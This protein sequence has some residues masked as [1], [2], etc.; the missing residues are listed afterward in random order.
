MAASPQ[1][2]RET[3]WRRAAMLAYDR[4]GPDDV[5]FF[6]LDGTRYV[7]VPPSGHYKYPEV[8]RHIQRIEKNLPLTRKEAINP[9]SWAHWYCI[10]PITPR[11]QRSVVRNWDENAKRPREE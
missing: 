7:L 3:E 6:A 8:V 1:P 9:H 10:P 11:G 4:L 2:D 5:D